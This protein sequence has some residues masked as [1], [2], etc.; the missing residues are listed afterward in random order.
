MMFPS[1]RMF[2]DRAE[3]CRVIAGT[4]D[5]PQTREQM[6]KIAIGYERLAEQLEQQEADASK[7]LSD[8]S[9]KEPVEE[10]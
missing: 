9:A 5:E 8:A 3:E 4:F 7:A 10:K 1:S 6:L 2:R